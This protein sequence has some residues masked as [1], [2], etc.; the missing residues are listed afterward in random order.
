MALV[1][2]FGKPG[3]DLSVAGT[4]QRPNRKRLELSGKPTFIATWPYHP[5]DGAPFDQSDPY[6]ALG[7][8][9]WEEDGGEDSAEGA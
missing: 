8:L 1:Y 4:R 9:G 7:D 3:L 6:G 5:G 2:R